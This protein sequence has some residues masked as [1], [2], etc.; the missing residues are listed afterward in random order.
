MNGIWRWI[1]WLLPLGFVAAH[2][3]TMMALNDPW[4]NW[5]ISE[6]GPK[7]M[8]SAGMFGACALLTARL[9]SRRW[10]VIPT[11]FRGLLVVFALGSAFVAVEEISYGQTFWDYQ[12]P[13]WF[14]THNAQD[15]FNLHNLAGDKPS[16][17][18][19][20]VGEIGMPLFGLMLPLV[21]MRRK[22]GYE[23]G[24]VGFHLFPRF[25]LLGAVAGSFAIRVI[26]WWR[27]TL[28]QMPSWTAGMSELQELIWAFAGVVWIVEIK[29]RVESQA[30]R[31][32]AGAEAGA[33]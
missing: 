24:T 6:Y 31:V 17:L 33:I 8:L 16:R 14:K 32:E 28:E 21:W 26:W 13:E 9:L 29:R 12:S 25:E 20:R 27:K 4:Q 1:G 23:V 10:R 22:G 15:E 7:E 19:R 3:A 11:R 30:S 5:F 2:V 18:L